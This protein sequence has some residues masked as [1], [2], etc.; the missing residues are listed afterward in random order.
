MPSRP[1]STE[2]T[3][4]PDQSFAISTTSASRPT[5]HLAGPLQTPPKDPEL[6]A[7]GSAVLRYV[8]STSLY[9]AKDKTDVGY[10]Q[11]W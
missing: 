4:A 9:A 1:T 7:S 5:T 6:I 11:A 2:S 10:T 8:L 3:N